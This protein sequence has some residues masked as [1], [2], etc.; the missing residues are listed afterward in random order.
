MFLLLG[1]IERKIREI[2]KDIGTL[3]IMEN[4]MDREKYEKV[5]QG[6]TSRLGDLLENYQVIWAVEELP[7]II[8][9]ASQERV[10][11]LCEVL[12]TLDKN[13]VLDLCKSNRNLI[14]STVDKTR[15]DLNDLFGLKEGETPDVWQIQI[16]ATM[17]LESYRNNWACYIQLESGMYNCLR[18]EDICLLANL[19]TAKYL[20]RWL[21]S[22]EK[23][24]Q[25]PSGFTEHPYKVED[26]YQKK[27][28]KRAS[29]GERSAMQRAANHY[30]RY[31]QLRQM[32]IASEGTPPEYKPHINKSYG[33]PVNLV[34]LAR[35]EADKDGSLVILKYLFE[36]KYIMANAD[37]I[38][39]KKNDGLDGAWRRYLE[40]ISR[41]DAIGTNKTDPIENHRRF[42]AASMMLHEMENAHNFLLNGRIAQRICDGSID[43]QKFSEEAK[44][45]FLGRFSGTEDYL[46]VPSWAAKKAD[47]L[48]E[49]KGK[50]S[51]LVKQS[52][53]P[54]IFENRHM[55][56]LGI[57]YYID[58]MYCVEGEKVSETEAILHRERRKIIQELFVFVCALY[59]PE[60]Q[61]A[62]SAEDFYNASEF[63][64]NCYPVTKKFLSVAYP[65]ACDESQSA[66]QE[67]DFYLQF[68]LQYEKLGS[69]EDFP[70]AQ[71]RNT[72][73]A[74]REAHSSG[75]NT[76]KAL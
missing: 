13:E 50:D 68:R 56:V 4:Q 38:K 61:K 48:L 65:N 64:R 45:I 35:Y 6:L 16:A 67:S 30:E 24:F 46:F 72:L 12:S 54:Y 73:K 44:E 34:T 29:E 3:H 5:Q 18:D 70:L 22:D 69:I 33:C 74:Q 26:R 8:H 31:Y 11:S 47:T 20:E 57:D 66:I 10:D 49:N 43:P 52:G 14:A 59:P 17:F 75:K 41:I 55:D 25:T 23:S 27:T 62:W 40:Y 39:Y 76:T 37:D 9:N 19:F 21:C 63:Y 53:E 36:N 51:E 15:K 71:G 32:Q 60:K 7:S 1:N 42:V 58:Q 2:C 28:G